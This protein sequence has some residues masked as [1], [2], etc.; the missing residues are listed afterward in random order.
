[1]IKTL[2]VDDSQS[3]RKKLREIIESKLSGQ[4]NVAGEAGSVME[5]IEAIKNIDPELV[6]LDIEMADGSGFDLL[7]KIGTVNF[8]VI[9]VT[10]HD[11]F[12]I[13]AFKFSAL[14][15]LLKPVDENELVQAIQKLEKR[16]R[17]QSAK[18]IEDLLRNIQNQNHFKKIALITSTGLEFIYLEDIVYLESDASYTTFHLKNKQEKLVSVNIGE[19]EKL[20]ADLQF[21]RIHNKHLINL[22]Y[23][24]KYDRHELRV[25][26]EDGSQLYVSRRKKSEF[27]IVIKSKM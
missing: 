17:R 14:D 5:G 10:A 18:Q 7:E 27:E 2:I 23:I 11:E 4:L 26:M 9:F 25:T 8:D 20:L 1:M 22:R 21:F 13:R 12:A 3:Y 24:K 6:F 16:T 15:Y 19:Y